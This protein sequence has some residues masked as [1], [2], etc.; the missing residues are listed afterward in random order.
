MVIQSS[1]SI[2]SL[3]FAAVSLKVKTRRPRSARRMPT[4]FLPRVMTKKTGARSAISRVR[5][6]RNDG[7]CLRFICS[8]YAKQE[9]ALDQVTVAPGEGG[10]LRLASRTPATPSRGHVPTG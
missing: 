6:Y 5:S 10:G 3:S 9:T 2:R 1:S 8:P 4:S 7:D